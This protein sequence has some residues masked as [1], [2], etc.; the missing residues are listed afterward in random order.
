M[1][2]KTFSFFKI[3]F[4]GIFFMIS[5]NTFSQKIGIFDGQTDIGKVLHKGTVN[6]N[7]SSQDYLISGSGANIWFTNDEFHFVW[8]KMKGDFIVHARG[9][10]LGKGVEE[11]RKFGDIM[12]GAY[13]FSSKTKSCSQPC[14]A[15]IGVGAA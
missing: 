9:K 14:G 15:G 10:F 5:A 13:S 11:H 12:R 2:V 4:A 7:S 8:K 6:Y 3:L 1:Y